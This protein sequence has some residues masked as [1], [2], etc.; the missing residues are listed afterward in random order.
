M[1]AKI[2]LNLKN[3]CFIPLGSLKCYILWTGQRLIKSIGLNL[4]LQV[5]I[6]LTDTLAHRE[7]QNNVERGNL[8]RAVAVC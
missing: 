2:H 8:N 7:V 1:N 5:L 6:L 4:L 3:V